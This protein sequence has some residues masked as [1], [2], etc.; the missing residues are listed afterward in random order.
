MQH[1][2]TPVE[3]IRE[4]V[5]LLG[6]VTPS[7]Y[8]TKLVTTQEDFDDLT[9]HVDIR[10]RVVYDVFSYVVGNIHTPVTPE[11]LCKL[12]GVRQ[13]IVHKNPAEFVREKFT[14]SIEVHSTMF[15]AFTTEKEDCGLGS[16]KRKFEDTFSADQ[17]I[18]A[19]MKG[20]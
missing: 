12:F 1:L 11:K 2:T 19:K 14:N 6:N 17:L 10:D 3:S 8:R 18:L 13:I 20:N 7:P 15:V 9:S 16:P 5:R 4:A